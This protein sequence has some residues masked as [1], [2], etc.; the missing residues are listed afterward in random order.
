VG[1]VA[2]RDVGEA[3]LRVVEERLLI[4]GD[5]HLAREPVHPDAQLVRE[6]EVRVEPGEDVRERQRAELLLVADV[7]E[8]EL[9]VGG[10]LRL[11][12]GEVEQ[13]DARRRLV[14]RDVRSEEHTSELQSRENLV[15]RLLLEK[16]KEIPSKRESSASVDYVTAYCTHHTS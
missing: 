15:C 7:G 5:L 2:A 9:H 13:L 6:G 12:R 11:R 1:A 4:L 16:K 10:A 8:Q 3:A 14:R